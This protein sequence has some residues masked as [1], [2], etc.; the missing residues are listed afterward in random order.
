[1]NRLVSTN[2]EEIIQAIARGMDRALEN[3]LKV[4][5]LLSGGSNIAIELEVMQQLQHAMSQKLRISMIDDRFVPLDSP[6]SNWGLLVKRGLSSKRATLVPPIVDFNL[7]LDEAA[8]DFAKRLQE[9]TQWAD[10]VIGQFGIGADGHTAGILPRSVG[11]HETEKPV[12][13]YEGPDFSRITTTPAYFAHIDL[14][15]AVALG[16]NKAEVVKRMPTA[17]SADE[18]PAQL[19]LQTKECIVYTDQPVTWPDV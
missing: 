19:L 3:N 10:V 9:A 1:M 11:V 8:A 15:I 2:R 18:Q 12:I 16:K 6:D 4:L 5:W 14:A 13:G 17:V 7:S